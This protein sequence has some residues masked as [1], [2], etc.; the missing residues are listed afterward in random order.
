M[1]HFEIW[2]TK[3]IGVPSEN[4][5]SRAADSAASSQSMILLSRIQVNTKK[6]HVAVAARAAFFRGDPQLHS[7]RTAVR[8][9]GGIGWQASL[10]SLNEESAVGRL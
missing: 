8:G 3:K 5:V 7:L 9:P 4:P 10:A 6:V 1:L 2:A